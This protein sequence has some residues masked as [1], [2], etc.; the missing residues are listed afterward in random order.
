VESS[1]VAD[2][3]RQET[4]TAAEDQQDAALA[5]AEAELA[6]RY[7]GRRIKPGSLRPAG[8][9]PAF[10]HKRTLVI[11]CAD[12]GAER[13]VATSDVFHVGRC[14]DCARKARKAK[15]GAAGDGA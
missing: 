12:C 2:A 14:V 6:R 3:G 1:P 7:P 11:L 5:A 8:A 4:D 9:D 10:G 15:K 13:A